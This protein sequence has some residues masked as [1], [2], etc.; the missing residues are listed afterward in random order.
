MKL[1]KIL[2]LILA[3]AVV[4]CALPFGAITVNAASTTLNGAT[5]YYSVSNNVATITGCDTSIS[6]EVTIPSALGGYPVTSIDSEAFGSCSSLTSITIPDSVTSIGYYAFN[7]CSSLTKVNITDLAA[8]CKIDFYDSSNPLRYAKNLYINGTLATN[9]TIPD[10]VTSIGDYAF[11]RCDSLT[12]VTIPNSVTSI[13]NSAFQSCSSLTQVTIP[14]SVTSIDYNAFYNCTSLTQVTIPD[15]VTSIGNYAF[16]NTGYYN[17]SSNWENGVLYIGNHLIEAETSISGSYEIKSGT[18]TIAEHA[19]ED[20]SSLTQVTIPDSVTSIGNYAFSWC[21]S[22]TQ[23]TIPDGVTSIGDY[24]FSGCSSLTQ[25]TIPDSVTSIGNKA[26]YECSSLTQVTIHDGVTSIGDYAFSGCS[27]LTQVTIHDGVT[28]IGDYAF[29]GCSSLTQVTIPD[30]VTSIGYDAFYNTGYYNNSSNWENGVLYIG[31][32][33][34]KAE[35]SISG[36]YEIKSG[37]KT[38]AE[39]AFEDCSSLTQV[40]I[41]DSVTSIGNKAFS[42]CGS[43]TQVTIHDGVTSI[44]S[45]AFQSCTSLT[46]VT[47]PD[48][49]TSIDDFAFSGCSSLTQV[50]I[51][52]GVTSIGSYAFQSCTSLTQVTIPD[53]VTSIDDF[54]FSGC[55]SLTQ[56]TIPDGVTSIGNYAFSWC[57]SLKTV[58]YCGTDDEWEN[59]S[60]ESNNSDLINATRYY[61]NISD[62]NITIP[63]TC[64]TD[65]EESGTCSFCGKEETRIILASHDYSS[66]F[67]TDKEAT[68]FEEGSK[69]RHCSRCDSITDVTIIPKTS[70]ADGSCGTEALWA[71]TSDGALVIIGNGATDNYKLKTFT[72]WYDYSQQI[73]SIEIAETITKIG[74][75][76]F[77]SL[78]N[79][80]K[81]NVNNPDT[82]FGYYVFPSGSKA[83]IYSKGNSA[84]EEYA[85]SNNLAFKKFTN[86]EKPISPVLAKRSAYSIELQIV[87]GYEYSIDGVNWQESNVFQ[88]LVSNKTYTFYQRIKEGAYA[89]SEKSDALTVTTLTAPKAPVI[90]TINGNTVTLEPNEGYEYSIDGATWQT[91]NVFNNVVTDEVLSFYQRIAA[92]GTDT[93]TPASEDAKCLI[94]S[95][96]KVFVGE[97]MLKVKPISGYEYCLDD[98]VWQESNV[99]TQLIPEETYTVY[100]RP[101]NT[102]GITVAYNNMGTTVL[103]NGNDPIT[104][105]NATH[106]AWLKKLLIQSDE[107]YDLAADFNGDCQVD[108]RDL[109]SLKKKIAG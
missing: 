100:Q 2:S 24:A 53:G 16:Y 20:C 18:K 25:V 36:S 69:S 14:D 97:T 3:L 65:G 94:V 52:D 87:D 63:A 109:V 8:W 83:T 11:Y 66:E 72:P 48:G 13:G 76:N 108:I 89:P 31:N 27:S 7:G 5:L 107:S 34:I 42:W 38:I 40:T 23:V 78:T 54:A 56:V 103:I 17:N 39:H 15:S 98:M 67:T 68:L 57:S 32:H 49:V 12:Q 46:Q 82:A 21:S 33:L 59:I 92:D 96:P 79:V 80:T 50:T 1:K 81:V 51:P 86:P 74:N 43:L 95:A 37:T 6:G 19:F 10:S 84:V 77:N 22:L 88:N 61:H 58:Y 47:I 35:T 60:I 101:K 90:A 64:T 41:P 99:F 44:G 70:V 102:N 104:S 91:N 105:P 9:I 62:W 73:K 75:Y 26:F 30:S 55:S 28:S 29:S 71:I 106:L 45:Y 93:E 85:K 4:M